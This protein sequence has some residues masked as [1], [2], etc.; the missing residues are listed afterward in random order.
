MLKFVI[1]FVGIY[2][3]R[4]ASINTLEEVVDEF[5]TMD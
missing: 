2:W 5:Y 3:Q 1:T 4:F